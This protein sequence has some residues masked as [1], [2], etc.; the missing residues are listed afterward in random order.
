M[1][2]AILRAST[3]HPYVVVIV[4]A[5]AVAI[6]AW[7]A[8][9]LAL[10]AIPDLSDTQVIVFAEWMGQSPDLVE[11][12]LTYPLV[13]SLV[14]VAGVRTVRGYSMF[15]MSFVY[16]I[17]DDGTDLYW[18]RSRVQ[19]TLAT[20][21]ARLPAGAELELGPDATGVGWALQYALVDESGQ[22]DSASLRLLQDFTL[23]QA[24]GAVDGVAEVA[25]LGGA[26]PTLQVEA[27]PAAMA[28]FGVD[29]GALAAAIRD[30]NG[31]SGG[32]LLELSERE[33]MVRMDGWLRDEAALAAAPIRALPGG[34][35]LRVGDVAHVVLGSGPRRGVTDLDGNG[36]VVGAIIVVRAFANTL[37]VLDGVKARMAELQ[38]TL[39]AGVRFQIT[40]DRSTVIRSSVETLMHAL[41]E[42]MLVVA[43]V[44]AL[45]L[46]HLRSTLVPVLLLPAAVILAFLPMRLLGV[47][48]NILSLGGIALAIGDL[49][50]AAIVLV[51]DA[52][53]KLEALPEGYDDKAR[54]AAILA[55]CQGVGPPIFLSLLLLV[56]SFLPIFALEGQAYRLFA[57]LAATKT[58]AMF[59]AAVLAITLAPALIILLVRGR[60][61]REQD[62]PI[63]RRLIAAYTPFARMAL[64]NPKSTL[65]IGALAVASAVPLWPQL[66]SEFM[67]T[68]DEG[69]ILAMPTTL[70]G[71]AVAEAQRTLQIQDRI[72]RAFPEVLSVHGKAG[73]AETSTD[74]APISMVETVVRL[75]PRAQWRRRPQPRFWQREDGREVAV[76]P[77][78]IVPLLEALWPSTR[79][80]TTAELT[81]EFQA[82]VDLPGWT[83]A[84]TMPI[85]TRIDMLSTGIRTPVGIKVF[86][87]ELGTIDRVSDRLVAALS[88]LPGTRAVFSERNEG[89]SFVDVKPDREALARRGLRVADVARAVE[90]GAGGMVLG[91]VVRGRVRLPLSLRLQAGARDNIEALRALPVAVGNA[92]AV[93]DAAGVGAGA[94]DGSANAAPGA[95]DDPAGAMA[96]MGAMGGAAD[97]GATP[98]A[99]GAALPGVDALG[100]AVLPTPVVRLGDVARVERRD[101]PPMLKNEDG[102][103]VGYVFVDLDP[104]AIDVGGWVHAAK[105]RV[106]ARGL[107]RE[108]RLVWT[109][110]YELLERMAE[111]MRWVI[112]LTLALIVGLLFIQ[113]GSVGKS[114]IVLFSVPFSLV[115]AVWLLYW[116]D[117]RLSTAVYV[118]MIALAGV[119][120]ETGIVM[121]IYLDERVAHFR[122][123]GRLVTLDDLRTAVLEGAALRLRPKLM[124]VGTNIVGLSPLL[125]ADGTG[126]DVMRRVVAPMVGGLVSSTF[127]TLEI[128]PVLYVAWAARQL[129]REGLD[130]RR[131]TG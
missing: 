110:Q 89:G 1:I 88:D 24:L 99:R 92:D 84:W 22:H 56:V 35:V 33:H 31:A 91:E 131:G 45:F 8:R 127:L 96:G 66:G 26:A 16:C 74:P 52:H 125:F 63:S 69:D 79:P 6:A 78:A 116:L 65:L 109:G 57:P 14:G 118:G 42:E 21:Q 17:F 4:A 124:T 112:P 101:G 114:A 90:V 93:A 59:F 76:I 47:S 68:L 122:Q 49:V 120:A 71:I 19:E 28:R 113:F 44:I 12:Q 30:A 37:A 61:R 54:R 83:N 95:A 119:A 103:L 64:W 15:G 108:A 70:P 50:D 60:I 13:S 77:A 117:Y 41:G 11:D 34:R 58:F 73:R 25:T 39:P 86:A 87:D 36:E 104:D 106:A 75:R 82:A 62:H 46:L 43:L 94:G 80:M 102:S 115:G 107:D 105:E 129:R 20:V 55:A 98:A 3:R 38:R 29:L 85:K 81:T 10:D 53:K 128:I 27:D 5:A 67:P 51:D 121:I 100:A 18:A 40:Y 97:G 126:A 111:R 2:D 23:K 130:L 72:L 9:D 7:T 32:G 48:S 123:N